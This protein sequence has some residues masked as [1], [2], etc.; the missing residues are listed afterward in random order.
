MAR[1]Q[2]I[3][4][5][6]YTS[7]AKVFFV[8]LPGSIS[9]EWPHIVLANC[10]FEGETVSVSPDSHLRSAGRTWAAKAPSENE[11]GGGQGQ[12]CKKVCKS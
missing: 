1:S 3:C 11:G 7:Y 4:N 12:M 2:H 5:C 10:D 6:K 8:F 9:K